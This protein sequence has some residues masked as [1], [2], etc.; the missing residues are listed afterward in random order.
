MMNKDIYELRK[1]TGLTQKAFA[2]RF[3]IPVSTLRKWEQGEASP[4]P[5][6]IRLIASVLPGSDNSDEMIRG[7]NG[8]LYYY[9]PAARKVTDAVGN[10]ISVKEDLHAVKPQNLPL[11]L[12]DLFEAFR[13][14]QDRFDR[15]CRF[16]QEEDII[17]S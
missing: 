4:P 9:R 10:T 8:A 17:W 6:V 15:D 11:Y 7:K 3:G 5:Y 1:G 2:E 14:I 12:D 13:D 16:D